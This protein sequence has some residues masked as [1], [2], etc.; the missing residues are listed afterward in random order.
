[1]A[2]TPHPH[3][4]TPSNEIKFKDSILL[5][6]LKTQSR[7]AEVSR[8]AKKKQH[9]HASS[10]Q[11]DH[12]SEPSTQMDGLNFLNAVAQ[13]LLQLLLS[14]LQTQHFLLCRTNS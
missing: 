13:L 3:K 2:K 9:A 4:E 8:E 11:C 6:N 1:M 12:H 5:T 7:R 10:G 14:L